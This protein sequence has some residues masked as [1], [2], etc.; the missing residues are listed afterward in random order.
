MSRVNSIEVRC[1]ASLAQY[2][3]AGGHT[4]FAAPVTA[5][6]VIRTLGIP[7]GDVAI[8]FV[9]GKRAEEN[10]ELRDGDRVGLFPA[11]GGG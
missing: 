11:V 1:F 8:L 10:T 9:N 6:D 3:T 2:N 7:A 4:K 5:G